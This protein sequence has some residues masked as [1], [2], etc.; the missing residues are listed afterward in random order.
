MM[1]D[2]PDDSDEEVE[3]MAKLKMPWEIESGVK[4]SRKGLVEFITKFLD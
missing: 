1:W 2:G 3:G 4:F